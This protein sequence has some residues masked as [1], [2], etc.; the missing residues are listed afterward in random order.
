M[1][2]MGIFHGCICM[3]KLHKPWLGRVPTETLPA[4][5][6]TGLAFL[7]PSAGTKHHP[8]PNVFLACHLGELN[9]RMYLFNFCPRIIFS[10]FP[11]KRKRVPHF[12]HFSLLS[13]LPMRPEIRGVPSPEK[14]RESCSDCQWLPETRTSGDLYSGWEI[15]FLDSF[16]KEGIE[17]GGERVRCYV[18]SVFHNYKCKTSFWSIWHWLMQK[19]GNYSAY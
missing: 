13:T 8:G 4:W 12:F 2:L 17:L 10:R 15:I 11:S 6:G 7:S 18:S 14:H 3:K 1:A 5:L 19:A 16:R 9:F